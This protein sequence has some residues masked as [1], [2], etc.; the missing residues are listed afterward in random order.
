MYNT[1]VFTFFY[2]LS[3]IKIKYVVLYLAFYNQYCFQVVSYLLHSF[4]W[5]YNVLPCELYHNSYIFLLLWIFR[6]LG[7]SCF[8]EFCDVFNVYIYSIYSW[9]SCFRV[10]LGFIP[11]ARI[12]F[13]WVLLCHKKS[14]SGPRSYRR[15]YS[16]IF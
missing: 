16:P 8:K 13:W 1:F 10:F 9:G 11:V 7:W 4:S 12:S 5:M 3:V 15:R 2:S 6:F 14:F